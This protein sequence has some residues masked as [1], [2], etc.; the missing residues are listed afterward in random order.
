MVSLL[1]GRSCSSQ[2]L[3]A[4]SITGLK[5]SKPYVFNVYILYFKLAKAFNSILHDHL[6]RDIAIVY[7]ANFLPG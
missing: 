5:Y 7:L 3:V 1:A 2:L 6:I 4:A